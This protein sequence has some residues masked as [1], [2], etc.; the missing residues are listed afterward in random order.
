[1]KRN[2]R[3][4]DKKPQDN[5]L[6]DEGPALDGLKDM[7][8]HPD[9]YGILPF[10]HN[11]TQTGEEILSAFF[12]PCIKIIANRIDLA[13]NRGFY[14]TQKA[15]EYYDSQRAKKAEDPRALITFCAE[16]C[17]NADEAFALEGD[18][19]FNKVLIA[20]QIAAIN[21]HKKGPKIETGYL[22]YMR[23]GNQKSG[24]KWIPHNEGKVHILEHPVWMLPPEKDE[25]GNIVRE[26]TP[27]MRN[28][29]VAGI[30]SIDIG[31][32][33]TSVLTKDPSDFCIVIK[34]RAFG[35]QEPQ[36]VAY[37]KDRPYDVREAYKIA[38][39][40]CQYYNCMINIEATRMTMV[41]WAR[42]NGYIG[43]FM[44][45]PRATMPDIMRGRSN[46][47]GSPA[48]VAVIDHQTDLIADFVND[49]C[50]TIW[51]Y[52]MLEELNQYNDEN[53]TKFDLVAAMGL[54]ELAD[55]ELHGVVARKVVEENNTFEDIGFYTDENGYK[56]YGVI[57][58]QNNSFAAVRSDW[59]TVDNFYRSS[60][61]RMWYGY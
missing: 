10:R 41:A 2:Y 30:D 28:L 16:F 1:M 48:T 3:T 40:M 8:Y 38:I 55:E 45:R 14:D 56:K 51:F 25:D 17:Y 50:H 12:I 58:K 39:R 49:Y 29:Y 53:K 26:A 35:N 36:Y 32:K 34:K 47:Y 60:D 20:E 27:E 24:F 15:K 18:N 23:E 57:P 13:D 6:G 44:R 5:N 21:L 9:K 11:Y 54:C 59:H 42:D 37:Y 61:T 19:K 46:S 31:G 4:K 43:M 52:E 7:Y 22:D 33:D